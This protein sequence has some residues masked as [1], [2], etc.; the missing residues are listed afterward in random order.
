MTALCFGPLAKACDPTDANCMAL[1]LVGDGD[2]L[3]PAYI[4]PYVAT[5]AGVQNVDVICDDF[6]TESSI[7]PGWLFTTETVSSNFAEAKFASYGTG[8]YEEVAWLAEQLQYN[9]AT[10]CGSSGTTN[11]Q[12]DIQYAIWS[13]FDPGTS[14][15]LA[16]ISGVDLST[17]QNLVTEAAQNEGDNI[18]F[19]IYTASALNSPYGINQSQEF[20][21]L[22]PEPPALALLAVDLCGVLGAVF[23]F[24]RRGRKVVRN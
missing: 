14:G 23:F 17:A 3:G 15:A 1:S 12:G 2:I 22:T 10:A 21:V 6:T 20:I 19:T 8:A 24:I 4:G 9:S 16:N 11:C 13:I 5:I 18:G 7:G